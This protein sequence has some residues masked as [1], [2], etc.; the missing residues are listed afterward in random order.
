MN[1]NADSGVTLVSA[2]RLRPGSEARYRHL[3]HVAA[4]AA[5][6]TGNLIRAELVPAPAGSEQDTVSLLTFASRADLDRWVDSPERR[7]VL[8]EMARLHDGGRSINVLSGFP[9]WYDSSAKPARWRQAI[10]IT[11]GLIPTSLAT[12]SARM[13]LL[14]HAGL[15]TSVCFVSLANVVVLTWLVLPRLNRLFRRLLNG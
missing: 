6:S 4:S 11:A 14:P 10:V 5:Q 7:R 15:V 1:V 8:D 13:L 2:V 12:T 3:H 9:A